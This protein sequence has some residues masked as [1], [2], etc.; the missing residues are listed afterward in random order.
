MRRY[1]DAEKLKAFLRPGEWGTPDERWVPEHEIGA[2][3]DY[4]P[5]ADVQEVRHGHWI[6][7][8]KGHYF[9][10]WKCSV[11]GGSGRADYRFCPNCGA[12]MEVEH[13]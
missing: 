7:E 10:D 12:K 1:I 5:A 3:I 2:L 13:E 8:D 6:T 4:F 9:Y 11:C